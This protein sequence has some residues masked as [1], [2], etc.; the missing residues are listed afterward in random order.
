[1][2]KVLPLK[3]WE[4]HQLPERQYFSD[5]DSDSE[6][7]EEYVSDEE[8]VIPKKRKVMPKPKPAKK[9][10]LQIPKKKSGVSQRLQQA[11]AKRSRTDPP[12]PPPGPSPKRMRGSEM[13]PSKMASRK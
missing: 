8:I 4:K 5:Q 6:D 11:G 10:K 12:G 13:K 1:M 9:S 3:Q 7:D 2:Q